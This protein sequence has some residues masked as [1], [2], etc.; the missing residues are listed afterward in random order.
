M[1]VSELPVEDDVPGEMAPAPGRVGLYQRLAHHALIAGLV[2]LLAG[3]ALVAFA[4]HLGAED[5]SIKYPMAFGGAAAI[6]LGLKLLA[7]ARFGMHFDLVL[8]MSAAWVIAVVLAAIFADLL[9]LSESHDISVTIN[10]PIRE[11]PDLLSDHPFG[12][13]ASGLDI[14]GGVIYGARVSLTVGLGAVLIG[15]TLGAA[16]GIAA[17]YYRGKVDTAVS[18]LTDSMLAFP[19]LILLLA[20]VAVMD[21][22]VRNV[23]VA[24]AVISIP[25]Y[26]RLA[27]ANTLVFAQREF[28]LAARALGDKNR[29][30]MFRELL[31]NVLL[32]IVSFSFLI[33]AVL[34]VAEASL[35]FL[36]LSVPRPTPTWGNMIA[37][38]QDR[39]DEH[40]HIV[41]IPG[42]VLFLTVFSFNRLGDRARELW[43]PREAKI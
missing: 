9:P 25:T 12:T 43:D 1:A 13:D 14:L 7:V 23:T 29:N 37:S 34:I 6:F 18:L 11:R 21:P 35:S 16:V 38:G 2:I 27:R 30:I 31:P 8:W 17:G 26:V 40:P 28:V 15:M 41:F 10:E 36:G 4:L 42:A 5:A 22:N 19:P 39:F 3:V 32:P 33:V 20:M 24:L